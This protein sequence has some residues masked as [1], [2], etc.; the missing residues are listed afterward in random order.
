MPKAVV[1]SNAA[2]MVVPLENIADQ[3]MIALK[4]LR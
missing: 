4:D 1:D 2:D 3:I